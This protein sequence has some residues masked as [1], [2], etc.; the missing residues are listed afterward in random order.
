M[1]PHPK[2]PRLASRRSPARFP[3]LFERKALRPDPILNSVHRSTLGLC[4]VKKS[5]QMQ[6]PVHDVEGGLRS[7]P[8]PKLSP[9]PFRR[10]RA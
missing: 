8:V 6:Q 4:A 3:S 7:R 5:V 2:K 9:T 1:P 10:I